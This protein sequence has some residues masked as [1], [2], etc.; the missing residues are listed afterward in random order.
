MSNACHFS[1][2]IRSHGYEPKSDVIAGKWI[3]FGRKAAI[4]ARLYDDELGGYLHD[5][6]TGEKYYW[7]ADK[8]RMPPSDYARRKKESEAL[9]QAQDAKR[10]IAYADASRTAEKLFNE[11]PIASHDHV[12]LMRKKVKPYGIKQLNGELLIPVYSIQGDMQSIQ[13]I[14]VDGNKKFLKGGKMSGGCHFIGEVSMDMPVY[15]SEGYATAVSVYEDTQCLSIVAFNA[16]NLINVAKDLRAQF[17]DIEIVIAGDCDEV[18]KKYAEKASQAVNGSVL[19][20]SFAD[21]PDGYTD[22][23]DYFNHWVTA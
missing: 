14:D 20:P 3:R 22:W 15:I 17:P 11:A 7:F 5:W 19:I 2:F 4:S 6:R 21:N 13:F 18:G 16:G 23:N 8:D 12:Y 1:D 9:K 10:S